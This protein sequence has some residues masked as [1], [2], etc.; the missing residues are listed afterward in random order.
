M[1]SIHTL[2]RTALHVVLILSITSSCFISS[3][4]DDSLRTLI[5]RANDPKEVLRLQVEL[6]DLYK[7]NNPDSVLAISDRILSL[8][9]QIGDDYYRC[10]GLRLKGHAL[11]D[12]PPFENA[13]MVI[14]EAIQLSTKIGNKLEMGK[15]YNNLGLIYHHLGNSDKAL[16]LFLKSL[17]IRQEL[18]DPNEI[19]G[20]LNNIGMVYNELGQ[21]QQALDF[22]LK[23]L[24]FHKGKAESKSKAQLY[25]N[26]ALVYE[27]LKQFDTALDYYN[28]A[29]VLAIQFNDKFGQSL[30]LSN[31]GGI[32][33]QTNRPELSIE[34][35]TKAISLQKEINH[36]WGLAQSYRVLAN[37]Y[38]VTNR[39]QQA[40][41][42]AKMSNDLA[43]EM[44][45]KMLIQETS[46]LLSELYSETGNYKEALRY[47]HIYADYSD[48]LSDEETQS[49][50]FRLES[51]FKYNQ[52]LDDLK[53]EQRA[54]ELYQAQQIQSQ[55]YLSNIFIGAFLIMIL[56][57][58]LMFLNRKKLQKARLIAEAASLAKS[59]FVTNMSHEIRTPLNAVI[60]F[61]D[62]LMRTNLKDDQI[63][64][65]TTV[66]QSAHS[67]LT[68]V[69][70][71]LDFSKI[72]SGKMELSIVRI[73]LLELKNQLHSIVSFQ[74]KEK[75]LQLQYVI[76][77]NIPRYIWVDEIR[78]RQILVNL[79]SNAIKFTESG[80]VTLKLEV[81]RKMND[82][83][84]W[85]RFSVI[86]TGVGIATTN[87]KKIFDAFSQEDA[88]TSRKFGGTGLGLTISNKLLS[89]MNT[90]LKL[91]SI[92]GRG[93]IFYFDIL[94]TGQ[95]SSL[96]TPEEWQVT[97]K[98]QVIETEEID[99]APSMN[100]DQPEQKIIIA[101]DN[102]VNLLLAKTLIRDIFPQA[103]LIVAT[104]GYECIELYKK[105]RPD[106]ILMDVQMPELNGYDATKAIR[107]IEIGRRIPIIALTAGTIEGEREKCLEAG[108][109]DYISKPIIRATFIEAL[110]RWSR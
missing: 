95:F 78:L 107:G 68:I 32:Y 60:G 52:Q 82:D 99:Q 71:I 62:L 106:M 21:H 105:E 72:E 53:E 87:Q 4:Q 76:G 11:S 27:N 102:P 17:A 34:Y 8:S 69:N 54:K 110:K 100:S 85:F 41:Q 83:R 10:V 35:L 29:L 70:D 64:Y 81:L 108:M 46:F 38:G 59:E 51:E 2:K 77:P 57:A 65:A 30:I 103:Y 58:F 31:I 86:D 63:Q 49:K 101:E 15:N 55:T 6:G 79:M 98:K 43:F 75:K 44:N 61:S 73:D 91:E 90:S 97:S 47:H 66:H 45:A 88:G 3:G 7:Y 39:F 16:D 5:I 18:G 1:I 22:Y 96:I 80:G 13:M 94:L 28:R 56:L 50:L 40:L 12:I 19:S 33:G 20:S 89:L 26:I 74:A 24:D 109:D 104:N 9:T 25:N 92:L 93:S 14:E 67:L 23:A 36:T 42:Y 84:A 37:V 48:S